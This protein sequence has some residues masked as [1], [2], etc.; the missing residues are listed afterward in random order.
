MAAPPCHRATDVALRVAVPRDAA[1]D[2][3]AGVRSK[4]EGRDGVDVERVDVVDLRPR[5]NDLT[6]D[7]DASV[8]LAPDVGV[9]DLTDVVGVSEARSRERAATDRD[10]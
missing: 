8:R 4:L 6:V 10:R 2:L 9:A 1:G 7:V 3:H 5:L